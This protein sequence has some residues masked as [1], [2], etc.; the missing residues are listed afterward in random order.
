MRPA[1]C[2]ILLTPLKE[3]IYIYIQLLQHSAPSASST[4]L[5]PAA[6]LQNVPLISW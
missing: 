3:Y 2:Y 6:M 1:G 4:H 5:P